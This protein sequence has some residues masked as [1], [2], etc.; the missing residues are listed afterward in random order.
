MEH[1]QRRL[2][3]AL[4]APKIDALFARS[5]MRDWTQSIVT[6]RLPTG[7]GRELALHRFPVNR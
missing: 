5:V 4:L 6:S 3:T 7:D 2:T 1:L